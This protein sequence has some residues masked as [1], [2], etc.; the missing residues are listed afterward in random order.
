MTPWSVERPFVLDMEKAEREL[1]YAP[2]TTYEQ[3]LPQT[4]DW[5]RRAADGRDWREVF[6]RMAA[7]P[8][9]FFDYAAEDRLLANLR[10]P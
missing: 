8:E 4:L 10:R 1:G 2:V 7:L 6:T 5:L 9:D 3:A